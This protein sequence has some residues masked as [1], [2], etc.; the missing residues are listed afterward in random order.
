[1]DLGN[2]E[3]PLRLVLVRHGESARNAA[4]REAFFLTEQA[5]QLVAQFSY[6]DNPLTENGWRQARETGAVLRERF[7]VPDCLY[8]SGFRRASDTA[9]AIVG[10]YDPAEQACIEMCTNIFIRERDTGYGYNMTAQEADRAFPWLQEYWAMCGGFYA[11]PPGGESLAD[12]VQRVYLFLDMLF[13]SREGKLIFVV[14]HSGTTRC[15]RF[16]LERWTHAEVEA[17]AGTENCGVTVYGYDAE[18]R[19]MVLEEANTICWQ[20]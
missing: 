13:R 18:R 5:R 2:I 15:F 8:H 6:A 14:T 16:L 1:M 10:A 7:G 19:R 20:R 12:V 3:R 9:A 17:A 11:R 4:K